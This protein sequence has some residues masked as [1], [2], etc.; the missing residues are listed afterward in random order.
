MN[1]W[2]IKKIFTIILNAEN[3]NIVMKTGNLLAVH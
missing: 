3:L 1:L 2:N